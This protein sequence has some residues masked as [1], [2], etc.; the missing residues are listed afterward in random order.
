M[1]AAEQLRRKLGAER[2]PS[3]R[4]VERRHRVIVNDSES[5]AALQRL[6]ALAEFL[7]HRRIIL[8]LKPFYR[9][10]LLRDRLC[11]RMRVLR[12]VPSK[13]RSDLRGVVAQLFDGAREPFFDGAVQ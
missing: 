12:G 3:L 1:D 4:S 2:T 13:L 10:W 11:F 6:L 5:K 8:G 9:V 7:H